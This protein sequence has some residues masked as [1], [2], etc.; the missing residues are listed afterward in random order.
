M[1]PTP[2]NP[3]VFTYTGPLLVGEFKIPVATG[4]FGCPYFRPEI[5]HPALTDTLAPY[6]PVNQ[7]P[8]D[9][10]DYKWYIPVAGTY[11]VTLNQLYETISIQQQ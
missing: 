9:V 2:G 8:A 1:T 6:V 11:K 10:N 3:Y 7:K 5:N 4:N